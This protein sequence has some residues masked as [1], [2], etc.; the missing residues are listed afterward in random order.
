MENLNLKPTIDNEISVNY[1][2][3]LMENYFLESNID[4]GKEMKS[5]MY[6]SDNSMVLFVDKEHRLNII[7]NINNTTSG[8]ILYKLSP[9]GMTVSSFDIYHDNKDNTLRIVYARTYQNKSELLVS[10]SINLEKINPEKFEDALSWE[11]KKLNN[12]SRIIDHISINGEGVLCSNFYKTT[13]AKYTYF[14]YGKNAESY[15]LPENTGKVIQL[16]VGQIYNEFGI[17][18]LYEMKN[19]NTMLFQSFPDEKYGEISAYRF[20]TENDINAFSLLDNEQGNSELYLA[21]D[22][23]FKFD[24]PDSNKK[25]IAQSGQ[26]IEYSKIVT[27]SN[28]KEVSIWTIGE[29]DYKGL[30][31]CSNKFYESS[32]DI[33]EKWT[34]PLMLHDKVEEFTCLK[35]DQFINQLFIF[36][37]EKTSNALTHIWQDKVSTSWT[38]LPVHL[39]ALNNIIKKETFTLGID[40]SSKSSLHS[41]HEEKVSISAESNMLVYINDARVHIGP[42][43]SFETVIDG[44]QINIIYPTKNIS[45]SLLYVEAEFL[46]DKI[47]IDPAHKLKEKLKIKFKDK[48]TLR[49]AKK[50]DG[51]SLISNDVSDDVLKQVSTAILI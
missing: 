27:A 2:G 35:G 29:K 26:G 32:T 30:Y 44:N 50:Q 41:F 31:Y 13:D 6:N 46:K 14:R 20:S 43:N 15:T 47:S 24:S 12:T 22:G 10:N 7:V 51:S 21:G 39:E 28:K 18:V 19:E 17:F 23:L 3:E 33:K 16:E 8:W 38:E 9:I 37:S 45:P 36:D 11:Q 34:N 4:S 5:L 25:T 42:E 40:F 49:N 1:H 48:N